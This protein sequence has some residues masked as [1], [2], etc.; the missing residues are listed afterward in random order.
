MKQVSREEYQAFVE[1]Y[2]RELHKDVWQTVEPSLIMFN[3][4]SLGEWPKCIVAETWAYSD[5][6]GDRYYV[7]MKD[8]RYFIRT[9]SE[10]D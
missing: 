3:D 4:L 5:I 1:N 6:P 9:D 2:P 10:E 8:R 7:P